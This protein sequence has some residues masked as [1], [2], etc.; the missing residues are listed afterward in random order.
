MYVHYYWTAFGYQI[1]Y[2]DDDLTHYG[3]NYMR[4]NDNEWL[5]PGT[6]ND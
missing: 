4:C 1:E 5:I 2:C 6:Y 3:Q